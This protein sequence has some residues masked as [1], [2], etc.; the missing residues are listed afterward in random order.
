MRTF[1]FLVVKQSCISDKGFYLLMF[2]QKRIGCATHFCMVIISFH[3]GE[4]P[5]RKSSAKFFR[6]QLPLLVWIT[7]LLEFDVHEI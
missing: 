2:L 5:K 7:I 3:R 1:V 6:F 4:K